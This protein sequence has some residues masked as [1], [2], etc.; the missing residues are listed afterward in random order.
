MRQLEIVSH[1]VPF[2]LWLVSPIRVQE[3]EVEY[4]LINALYVGRQLL[5]TIDFIGPVRI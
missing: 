3:I 1:H 4:M 5:S 2:Q